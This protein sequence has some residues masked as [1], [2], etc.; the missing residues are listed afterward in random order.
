MDEDPP[1]ASGARRTPPWCGPPSWCATGR[2]APWSRPATRGP[3]WPP[4]CCAWGACRGGPALHRHPPAAPR[5]ARRPC[6]STP[7]PTPS[8]R[9]P[10]WCSSRRWARPRRRP[11]RHAVADGGPAVDRRGA[12][13]GHA[14]GQGDP[15]AAG[16]GGGPGFE[17]VGNLEGRDLL[18]CPADVIVTD[19]FTG[20]VT[21]KS[22]EGSLRF[23]F[24]TMVGHLRHRRRDQGARLK[25]CCRTCSRWRRSST[26][27]TPA[28][29]C[30]SGSTASA[31]SATARP[32]TAMINAVLVAH[33]CATAGPGRPCA[34]A[35]ARP[36]SA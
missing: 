21:L 5:P 11:L 12:H 32:R 8:A 33:E 10:C 13:E 7:A 2:P 14:P 25:C 9:P 3:P 34:A 6:W 30:C 1:R 22:L 26:P 35:V 4:R 23:L 18:P 31:S 27:R 16:R 29:P 36:H 24:D 15:R 17:F 20:N 19:G 28:G